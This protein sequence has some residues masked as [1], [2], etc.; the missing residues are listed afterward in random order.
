MMRTIDDVLSEARLDEFAA[1][2]DYGRYLTEVLNEAIWSATGRVRLARR[3][4]QVVGSGTAASVRPTSSSI[5]GSRSP[6]MP[7]YWPSG[8]PPPSTGG[9]RPRRC[10]GPG[11]SCPIRGAGTR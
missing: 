3:Y 6:P 1:R 5:P 4:E 9:G 2:Q 7:S 11:A 10:A 8:T